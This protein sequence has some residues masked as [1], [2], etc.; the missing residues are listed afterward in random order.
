MWGE[1]R[2]PT[3]LAPCAPIKFL[4]VN[5]TGSRTSTE[6]VR[7]KATD[8]PLPPYWLSDP[9]PRRNAGTGSPEPP[10]KTGAPPACLRVALLSQAQAFC[11][12]CQCA[13]S[14]T[15]ATRVWRAD[16][17]PC[18]RA[19]RG[20]APAPAS[21]RPRRPAPCSDPLAPLRRPLTHTAPPPPHTHAHML[22]TAPTPGRSRSPWA[23]AGWSPRV[24]PD[25]GPALA[26]PDPRLGGPWTVAPSSGP[27]GGPTLLSF[28][29]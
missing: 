11:P 26:G 19:Y 5:N 13:A 23:N 1:R 17:C 18:T 27:W 4:S 14:Y 21:P 2:P 6:H 7:R 29:G 22:I 3:F 10:P 25:P 24:L 9:P 20:S 12:T 8:L 28:P 16:G 15:S